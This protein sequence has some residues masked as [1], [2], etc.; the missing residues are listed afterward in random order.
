VTV[1]RVRSGWELMRG[2]RREAQE[3]RGRLFPE[4]AGVREARDG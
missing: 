3:E 1:S 2:D 4:S